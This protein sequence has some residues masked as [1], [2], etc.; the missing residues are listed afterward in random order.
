MSVT[1][2]EAVEVVPGVF[3]YHDKVG[4]EIVTDVSLGK[5]VLTYSYT[6]DR[7]TYTN[8]YIT[9]APRRAAPL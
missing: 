5:T 4:G 6:Q 1:Y 9:A 8:F 2:A 3:E 7:G